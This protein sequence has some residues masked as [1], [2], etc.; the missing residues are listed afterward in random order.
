MSKL[1]S[2]AAYDERDDRLLLEECQ[3]LVE[4]HK[5][6]CPQ[7]MSIVGDQSIESLERVPFL[8]VGLFKHLSLVSGLEVG[9]KGRLLNSS[10]TSGVASSIAMDTR[11]SE[12]QAES[13]S[14]ILGNFLGT[15]KRPLL[16]LDS[17]KSLRSRNVSARVAA[18][19]SLRFLA[20][21]LSFLLDSASDP[22]SLRFEELRAALEESEEVVVYGFSWILW[23]A[24]A[25]QKFPDSI[26]SLLK[27]CRVRFVHSG[28]W[29]KLESQRVTR[30][31]LDETCIGKARRDSTVLDYYGLVEQVGVVYPLCE[32]G[33]RHV[34][35]W[36]E[37]F[38]RD[39]YT[40]ES[41]QDRRGQ[42]QLINTLA[43]GAPYHSVLTEDMGIVHS[44]PCPCGRSGKRFSLLGRLPKSEIRG[45]SN[46]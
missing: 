9:Q 43:W 18:A 45:C 26:A 37:I 14:K 30:K 16:I 31:Q 11:S 24:W 25:Q 19:M 38:V 22:T 7:Y 34:P 1:L 23:Q 27:H 5:L 3:A 28:G 41:V 2:R 32:H 13:S 6:H 29:K 46:V 44:D 8:H 40:L 42:I 20:S 39:S 35:R 4:Y 12:L 36:A 33:Y 15:D 10:S 17:A 21:K